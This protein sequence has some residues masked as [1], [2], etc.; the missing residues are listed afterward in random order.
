MCSSTPTHNWHMLA[1]GGEIVAVASACA[2]LWSLSVLTSSFLQVSLE[3]ALSG[4]EESSNRLRW[5]G[6]RMP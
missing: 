4:R 1:L 5:S 2:Y 3:S 6:V